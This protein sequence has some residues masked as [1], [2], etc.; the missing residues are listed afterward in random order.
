MCM[1]WVE[2]KP[3]KVSER[4]DQER[5]EKNRERG[6]QEAKGKMVVIG[7]LHQ[8]SCEPSCVLAPLVRTALGHS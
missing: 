4:N 6:A 7:T 8:W 2:K 1:G 5:Y 3:T